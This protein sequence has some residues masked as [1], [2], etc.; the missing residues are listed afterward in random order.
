MKRVNN[1]LLDVM[2]ILDEQAKLNPK[3]VA[4]QVQINLLADCPDYA[5]LFEK[6]EKEHKVITIEQR[7][8]PR[9]MGAADH[10]MYSWERPEEY[11]RYMSYYVKLNSTFGQFYKDE[12]TKHRSTTATLTD[13]N[14]DLV[15]AIMQSIDDE[16]SLTGKTEVNISPVQSDE[17][18]IKG[19]A[20]LKKV[21]AIQ[22]YEAVEGTYFHADYE[23]MMPSDDV[24]FFK[25]VIN[26]PAF[27]DVFSELSQADERPSKSKAKSS[28]QNDNSP[29]EYDE[30]HAKAT[31][32]G[33]T[34]KLF[35]T[36]TIMSILTH[37]VFRADGARMTA[38]AILNDI[39]AQ[40]IDPDKDMTTKTLT[41]AKDR[42]NSKFDTVFGIKDVICYE[43]QEF[44][45][46]DM[47]CSAK[48]GYRTT[49]SGN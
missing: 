40:R 24:E 44:W 17:Q 4:V 48:S 14:R 6:L 9:D 31:Y 1:Q 32:K 20:F 3:G 36:G 7:P 43:R 23:R 10:D 12:Y 42:I 27:D 47:Y 49:S 11:K 18:C 26:L 19:L 30:E 45:L 15:L 29:I 34:E 41:N 25:V 37:R 33:K 28:V 22:E 21:N 35:D 5:P 13:N 46:N 8:D 2:R 16:V 38:A 39:E